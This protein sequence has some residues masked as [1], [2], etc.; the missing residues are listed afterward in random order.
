MIIQNGTIEL[1]MARGGGIDD[2]TGHPVR[3]KN[4]EWSEPIPCQFIPSV[5][6]LA[7]TANDNHYTQSSYQILVEERCM[8]AAEQLR[9]RNIC[10]NIIGTYSV[11]SVTPLEAVSEVQIIV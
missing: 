2:E 6:R 4:D 3:P 7:R 9:L 11:I 5:N 1:Q 8:C 10:G